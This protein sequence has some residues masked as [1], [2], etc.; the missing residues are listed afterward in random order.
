MMVYRW[1]YNSYSSGCCCCSSSHGGGSYLHSTRPRAHSVCLSVC[2]SY[3]DAAS[4]KFISVC[5][6]LPRCQS[7]ICI[8]TCSPVFYP[9]CM[10]SSSHSFVFMSQHFLHSS[11]SA[12]RLRRTFV[13]N[14]IHRSQTLKLFTYTQ[15]TDRELPAT[16]HQCAATND[17]REVARVLWLNDLQQ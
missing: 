1:I 13:K 6:V 10:V 11:I 12:I 14:N 16:V 15:A 8:M 17:E 5:S 9:V 2:L 4:Y 7:F 3:A